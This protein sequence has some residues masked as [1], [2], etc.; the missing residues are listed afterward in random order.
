MQET[1]YQA[2]KDCSPLVIGII[3]NKMLRKPLSKYVIHQRPKVGAS[4]ATLSFW[5][6]SHTQQDNYRRKENLENIVIAI[7]GTSRFASVFACFLR[8]SYAC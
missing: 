3:A 1:Q 6:V 7:Y 2:H 5:C 4:S 8:L